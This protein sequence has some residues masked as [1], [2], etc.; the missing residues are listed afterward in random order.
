MKNKISIA[1]FL[2]AYC[3]TIISPSTLAVS[4]KPGI[5][6]TIPAIIPQVV[7]I[8]KANFLAPNFHVSN[9]NINE[10]SGS[11][12]KG[13]FTTT[14]QENYYTADLNYEMKLF[15]GTDFQSLKL[16]DLVAISDPFFIQ[17]NGEVAKSFVYNY[18]QNIV[19][20]DYTLRIQIITGRGMELG[21]QDKV[22]LLKGNNKFLDI[23]FLTAK[24][25]SGTISGTP[26][27]G[28]NVASTD[29]VS[30]SLKVQNTG[31]A[32]TVVPQIKIYK[33]QINMPVVK[34][35]ND[36]AI[37][38]AKGETK[39]ITLKMPKL[40]IPESY[41]AEV[42]FFENNQQV[43]GLQYFRWVVEGDSGK[44]IY[45]KADKDFYKAGDAINLTIQTVGPADG[46]NAGTGQLQVIV[47][48]KNK[49]QIAKIL[50][51]VSLTGGLLPSII[52]IPVKY[53]LVSP[54]IDVKLTKAGKILDEQ[55]INLPVF[56]S[57]AIQLEKQILQKKSSN[58]NY[59]IY[60][61]AILV[62]VA[63]ILIFIFYKLK[64][65]KIK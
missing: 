30:G 7:D 51:D 6:P 49:K 50:K 64:F 36:T 57:T 5:M 61:F 21:W 15:K 18:P 17:P 55:N 25:L 16:I 10:I 43:S 23:D 31:K 65:R 8:S 42:K 45:I 48:D 19:S 3:L 20:G 34:E 11:E 27:E 14:N 44:I 54:I 62:I 39:T 9:L 33:R 56:S 28:I 41:L 22:I 37:T 59:L 4:L 60:V 63:I 1:S 32:I 35:Y 12:I 40:D 24:V 26:L 2:V 38:F 58:I 53:D 47:S 29:D 13:N 52:S 46:S